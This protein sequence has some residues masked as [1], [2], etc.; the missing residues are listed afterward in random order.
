[1]DAPVNPDGLEIS[2]SAQDSCFAGQNVQGKDPC[3]WDGAAPNFRRRFDLTREGLIHFALFAHA[4]GQTDAAEP[5]LNP[6]ADG[7]PAT[8]GTNPNGTCNVYNTQL[9]PLSRSGVGDFGGDSLMVTLGFWGNHFL[10]PEF[11]QASTL[12]HELGHNFWL[13]HRG[14]LQYD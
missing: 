13:T 4:T 2:A 12:V 1:R 10:G 6:A 14:N 3:P 9:I 7:N 8:P 5:C 11:T